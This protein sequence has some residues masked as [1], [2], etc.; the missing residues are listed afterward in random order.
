MGE[1][2]G[3]EK[4]VGGGTSSCD[5]IHSDRDSEVVTWPTKTNEGEVFDRQLIECDV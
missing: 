2:K 4:E 3:K 5:S 1:G